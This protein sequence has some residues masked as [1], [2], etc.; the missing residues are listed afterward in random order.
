[1]RT[2]ITVALLAVLIIVG[3]GVIA[4]LRLPDVRPLLKENPQSTA[5]IDAR[6]DEAWDQGRTPRRRQVWVSLDAIAKHAVEAVV[7]AEDSSFYLHDGIDTVELRHAVEEAIEKGSLGRGASTIT[8]QLAKNLYLSNERSLFR[9]AKE[10]VLARRIDD[11]LTKRRILT[12]YLNVVEWGDGVYGIEAAS[13]EHFGI[14]ARELS[15]AQGAILAAMLPNPRKRL[16][17]NHSRGLYRYAHTILGRMAAAHRLTADESARAQREL[18]TFFGYVKPE[19]EAPG[20][21]S[22][23]DSD[24]D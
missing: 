5:L 11:V 15:P 14:H 12:L 24:S 3:W 2:A 10:M 18:S 7:L 21:E 13:Q 23:G 20:D 9:K 17:R 22:S 1:V 19:P 8:Q 16:P 4:Y 6:A